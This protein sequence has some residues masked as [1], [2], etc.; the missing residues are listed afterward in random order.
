MKPNTPFILVPTDCGVANVPGQVYAANESRFAQEFYQEALTAYT[1]GWRDPDLMDLLEF[2]APEVQ[3]PRWFQ[4]KVADNP[5]AFIS[6]DDD[7]RAV[8]AGFKLLSQVGTN[9]TAKTL[10]KGLTMRVD[11]DEQEG[12]GWRERKTA[13]LMRRLVRNEVRRA[14]AV[15]VAAA[16][17]LGK[18]WGASGTP[19][20]DIRASLVLGAN[21]SGV[22]PNR[23]AFDEG[24]FDL[25]YASYAQQ[26]NAGAYAALARSLEQLAQHLG[27]EAVRTVSAR[28]QA[29]SS[30]KS[31]VMTANTVLM[32]FAE[33][34]MDKDDA[35][36]V[37]RFVTNSQGGGRFA[38][39][40][41]QHAAFTDITV[42]HYSLISA[43][44]TLGV[45]QITG[46]AT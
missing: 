8:G 4:Y 7:I 41:E 25:R 14:L 1:V 16:T 11:V 18:T 40:E 22:R 2:L 10:S 23:I 5:S 15:I 38:V 12:D 3:T 9:A 46:S 17:N 26:E 19:D 13:Y 32:F 29:T 21:A 42:S 45:R 20:E 27:V 34:G 43:T 33:S 6:E 44:S 37:K 36:N 24:A 39:F 30:T 35:S 28:Y 31:R